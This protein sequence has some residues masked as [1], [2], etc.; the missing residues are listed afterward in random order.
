MLSPMDAVQ[1]AA[2]DLD[3]AHCPCRLLKTERADSVASITVVPPVAGAPPSTG[4]RNPAPHCSPSQTIDYLTCPRLWWLKRRWSRRGAWTPHLALGTAIHRG[5]AAMLRGEPNAT[6]I[7]QTTLL[8]EIT[9]QTGVDYE[10]AQ[11][12]NWP[13]D[14]LERLVDRG[15]D[16]LERHTPLAGMQPLLIE[17]PLTPHMIPD[18]ICQDGDSVTVV[19]LKTTYKTSTYLADTLADTQHDWQMRQY[20]WGWRA[21]TDVAPTT[22]QRVLLVL[23]PKPA[24]HVFRAPI[25]DLD[26]WYAQAAPIWTHMAALTGATLDAWQ[27]PGA[28]P[29]CRTKYGRCD[30]YDGCWGTD[31]SDKQ[32]G[33][34]YNQRPPR[35]ETND[36]PRP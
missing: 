23:T 35:L 13:L 28:T 32:L 10:V 27:L 34:L 19:D 9:E 1:D 20:A 31:L 3:A 16:A 29:Q 4:G 21:L 7:A 17:T 30:F 6:T 2:N 18:V 8:A 15:L 33:V 14:D 12:T 22:M 36:A 25:G 11:D 26:R 24:V 5:W